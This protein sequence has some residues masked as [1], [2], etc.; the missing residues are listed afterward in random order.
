VRSLLSIRDL[1]P[2]QLRALVDRACEYGRGEG[3][4][5][6]LAGKF[7]GIYFRHHSTRTR[8]AFTVAAQRL[9]A[10]AIVYGPEDLQI[11]TG[12]TIEDTGR[13]LSE[14]LDLLVIR[15]NE[16]I[17]EMRALAA[18]STMGIVNALSRDEH[19][20]QAIADLGTLQEAHGD[21]DGEHL[22][23]VGEGNSSAAALALACARTRGMRMTLMSPPGYGLPA[24]TLEEA[25]GLAAA[26]GGSVVQLHDLDQLPAECDAVYTSRWQTMGVEKDEPGWQRKFEGYK[27]TG[28]LIDRVAGENTIFLHDLPAVRG[29]DVDDD[30]LDGPHSWAW[31]QANYKMTGAMSVL[32]WCAEG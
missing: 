5:A 24:E 13:V 3:A 4:E 15:T 7:V 12:E 32:A 8:T 16:D 27:V 31:R 9:G 17:E 26:A 2:G 22:L 11:S 1:E 23:Y 18:S 25:A 29:V 10:Q 6:P 20:T 30:V 19:P 28:E 21:L 14:Y